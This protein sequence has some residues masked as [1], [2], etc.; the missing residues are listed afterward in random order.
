MVKKDFSRF[1]QDKMVTG[2]RRPHLRRFSGGC[3]PC[4]NAV[5]FLIRKEAVFY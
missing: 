1:L 3:Q 2:I 4:N 5:F